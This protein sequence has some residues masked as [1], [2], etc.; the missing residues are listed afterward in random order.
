[1]TEPDADSIALREEIAQRKISPRSKWRAH[2]RTDWKIAMDIFWHICSHDEM[3]RNLYL[4]LLWRQTECLI[5]QWWKVI[6]AVAQSLLERKSMT[7]EQLRAV[8]DEALGL[9]SLKRTAVSTR[10]PVMRT[11]S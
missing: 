10:R 1:M 6:K 7:D 11:E 8:I 3:A 5:D 9:R 4:S 2:G